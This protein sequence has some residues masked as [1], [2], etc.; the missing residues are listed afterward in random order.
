[1]GYVKTSFP[2]LSSAATKIAYLENPSNGVCYDKDDLHLQN[3][4]SPDMVNLEAFSGVLRTRAGQCSVF[5]KDPLCSSFHSI[6]K[7]PFYDATI[8]HNGTNLY[9]LSSGKSPELLFSDMPDA[10]SVFV[11]F[12]SKLYIYTS[13]RIYSV[14]KDFKVIEEMPYAPLLFEAFH[15]THE[16]AKVN[17]NNKF[18]LVAPALTVS[19]RESSIGA[20]EYNFPVEADIARPIIIKA[21]NETVDASKYTLSSKKITFKEYV[22]VDSSRPLTVSFFAKNIEDLGFEDKFSKCT[23]GE[24]FGGTIVSGT[25]IFMTGNSDLPGY[26]FTSELLDPLRFDEDSYDIIGSGN[27]NITAMIKQ[28]GNL[29]L[30]TDRSV[31][32]MTYEYQDS[33]TIFSVKELSH[34]IGCDIPRSVEIIDNRI[35]FANS[36]KGVFL[37]DS[38]EDFGEQN[39]KPISGNINEGSSVCLLSQDKDAIKNAFSIDFNRKYYL[40]VGTYV[41]VWDYNA[42]YYSSSSDYSSSQQRLVWYVFCGIKAH[43]FFELD[44]LLY[45]AGTQTDSGFAVFKNEGKDFDKPI[46]YSFSSAKTYLSYP[47]LFKSIRELMLDIKCESD[48][49]IDLFDREEKFFEYLLKHSENCKKSVKVPSRRTHLFNFSISGQGNMEFSNICVKF[50]LLN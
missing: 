1:M 49:K 48:A 14:D 38:S 43:T 8:L 19:Y 33:E 6:T 50:K 41:Y 5:G 42:R 24:T 32:R 31:F 47:H 13:L 15:R 22:F 4:Q 39:I 3:G 44:G 18:N 23:I 12:K 16:N 10:N 11:E 25:R 29:V 36:L 34:Y 30:F 26:Y 9:K 40:C 27:E 2:S 28:Y 21:E 37:I 17:T 20:T 35:V 7:Q 46:Q 45:T